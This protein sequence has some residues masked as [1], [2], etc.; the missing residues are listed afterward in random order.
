MAGVSW[1][2]WPKLGWRGG[3]WRVMLREKSGEVGLGRDCERA[4]EYD[5]GLGAAL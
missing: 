4:G 3:R 2:W 5:R 1:P